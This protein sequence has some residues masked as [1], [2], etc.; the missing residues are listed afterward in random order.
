MVTEGVV[1]TL[2]ARAAGGSPAGILYLQSATIVEGE[3]G[4]V[5]DTRL[6][7]MAS[8][9]RSVGGSFRYRHVYK[10]CS[11]ERSPWRSLTMRSLSAVTRG[12]VT[13]RSGI[14]PS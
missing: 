9:R 10:L 11:M 1:A 4:L 14:L 12:P 3:L 5:R 2:R 6:V 13:V 8:Q 7:L